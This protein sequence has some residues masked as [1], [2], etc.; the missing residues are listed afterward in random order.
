MIKVAFISFYNVKNL[1]IYSMANYVKKFGHEVFVFYFKKPKQHHI[2]QTDENSPDNGELMTNGRLVTP[3]EGAITWSKKEFSLLISEI[4]KIQ[5]HVIAISAFSY[6]DSLIPCFKD[7]RKSNPRALII[8]GG[9]GPTFSPEKYIDVCDYVVR[10]EGEHTLLNILKCIESQKSISGL[11]NICFKMN[12]EIICNNV[13]D[14]AGIVDD[15]QITDWGI[16]N[17]TLIENNRRHPA[18]FDDKTHY[19]FIGRG[20]VNS[21]TF[22]AAGNW[23]RLYKK[24]N[25]KMPS[26][27]IRNIDNVFAELREAKERGYSEIVFMDSFFVASKKYLSKFFYRYSKE[28]NIPFIANLKGT[29]FIHDTEL[30]DLACE[31]GL[32]AVPLGIQSGSPRVAWN[33]YKSDVHRDVVTF[34]EMLHKRDVRKIYQFILNNPLE[35]KEDHLESLNLIGRLPFS[36]FKQDA[37]VCWRLNNFPGI[38]LNEH[39]KK[40]GVQ[41]EKS[42]KWLYWAYL[43]SLRPFVSNSELQDILETEHFI[44]EPEKLFPLYKKYAAQIFFDNK[45]SVF[46]DYLYEEVYRLYLKEID[47]KK[48]IL[49]GTGSGMQKLFPL[50]QEHRVKHIIDNDPN[51]WGRKIEQIEI[52][53]PDILEKYDLPIFICAAGDYKKQIVQQ[54]EEVKPDLRLP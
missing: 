8:A 12:G 39:F 37:L 5:P 6:M 15:F 41:K 47:N 43:Y 4:N 33:I 21:C 27:R 44:S 28:V 38:P 14:H 31:A 1:G 34:S 53:G 18:S 51:K 29:Q 16:E 23:R 11:D 40:C 10:G 13:T 3:N 35:T 42:R 25:V 26:R 9:Y 19:T 49:W 45:Q 20:C 46:V 17:I 7:L 24:E 52:V 54:I 30:L 48:I 2:N 36:L 22:C 32:E 50:F